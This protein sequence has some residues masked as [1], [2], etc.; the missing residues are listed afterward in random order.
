MRP[1]SRGVCARVSWHSGVVI[2]GAGELPWLRLEEGDVRRSTGAVA[3][4][5]AAMLEQQVSAGNCGSL[6]FRS[7]PH[8]AADA[9][10]DRTVGD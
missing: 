4:W 8:G 1:E 6:R 5:L 2:M 10:T 9:P 7:Q 3:F